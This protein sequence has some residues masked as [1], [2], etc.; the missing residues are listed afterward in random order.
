[1]KVQRIL[2]FKPVYREVLNN[3]TTAGLEWELRV[4]RTK[5]RTSGF[6]VPLLSLPLL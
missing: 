1:M 3:L 4:P 6:L 5:P 2:P